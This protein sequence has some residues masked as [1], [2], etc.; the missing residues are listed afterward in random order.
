MTHNKVKEAVKNLIHQAQGNKDIKILSELAQAYLDGKLVEAMDR[1]E[2]WDIIQTRLDKLRLRNREELEQIL[3]DAGIVDILS[4]KIGKPQYEYCKI[5]NCECEGD[6]IISKSK[7]LPSE[8][9]ATDAIL[10]SLFNRGYEHG[11]SK[12]QSND[13][14]YYAV[15][16]AKKALLSHIQRKEK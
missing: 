16:D 11:L 9:E 5:S 2:I 12:G 1:E 6:A 8:V 3:I 7:P 14:E 4:G 15:R 10:E 13:G